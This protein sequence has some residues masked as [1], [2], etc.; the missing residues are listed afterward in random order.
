MARTTNPLNNTQIEKA[1][2]AD[3]DFTL[4]D[5]GGL[6][7]LVKK[8]GAKLWRFNY[9][10]PVTKKRI[11]IGLGR[12]PD[13]ALAQARA[14]RDDYKVLLAQGIDPQTRREQE[15][16]AKAAK[17]ENTFLALAERWKEKKAKEVEPSTLQKNWRRIEIYLFP[18]LAY[19]PISEITPNAVV[20]ALTPLSKQGK[21]DTLKRV[22]RLL[23]E[24][25]NFAVNYGVLEFNP[26]LSINAVFSFKPAENNPTIRPEALPDLLSAIHH[27]NIT[28]AIKYL[29]QFQLLT[30]TRPSEAAGA[31]WAEIDLDKKL[32]TI[33]A[34]RMKKRYEHQ[35]PLSTQAVSI[36]RF[37]RALNAGKYVFESKRI[38]G[39]P[40]NGQAAN[41]ALI[42]LGYKDRVTA[43]GLR[44]IASTYLNERLI[45]SDVVEACLSHSIKDRVRRAY[46]RSNYLEQR[47]EVMQLWGDYVEKCATI[48]AIPNEQ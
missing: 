7:L 14:I 30:M 40:I 18:P 33:P 2:A 48:S 11:L 6:Y 47:V 13:T 16:Q 15:A 23:N 10:H 26:C 39:A 43:H 41:K 4:S 17:C 27:S 25:L 3:S 12:Y 45:N 29:L 42:D 28:L 32:W 9:Y 34:E 20:T 46:N 38:A 19:M 5:G 21:S 35:I 31:E 37:M 44:S 22:I 24:V 1:K 8:S 36:L